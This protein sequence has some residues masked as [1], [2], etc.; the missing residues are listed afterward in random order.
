MTTPHPIF[1]MGG[2]RAMGSVWNQY[3]DFIAREESKNENQYEEEILPKDDHELAIM[4]A[5]KLIAEG[6]PVDTAF[7]YAKQLYG[8]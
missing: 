7:A 2:R 3:L 1:L 6:Y 4:L 8:I 5:R